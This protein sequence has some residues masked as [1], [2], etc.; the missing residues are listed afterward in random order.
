MQSIFLMSPSLFR[1]DMGKTVSK[2]KNSPTIWRIY[3]DV[4][5]TAYVDFESDANISIKTKTDTFFHKKH[6]CFYMETYP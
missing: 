3:E 1:A 6:A 5:F 2:S 4:V